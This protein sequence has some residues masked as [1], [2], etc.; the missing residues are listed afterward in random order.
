MKL[1][2]TKTFP[3]ASRLSPQESRNAYQNGNAS[4]TADCLSRTCKS[5]N[6]NAGTIQGN[7]IKLCVPRIEH[8]RKIAKTLPALDFMQN[9]LRNLGQTYE[10][11]GPRAAKLMRERHR[12]NQSDI[13]VEQTSLKSLEKKHGELVFLYLVTFLA[14]APF[15][16]DLGIV[17]SKELLNV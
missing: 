17:S 16:C 15:L 11:S 7:Y 8:N 12:L 2:L 4:F 13:T 1:A 6:R 9:S 5:V 14:N 10:I 3:H